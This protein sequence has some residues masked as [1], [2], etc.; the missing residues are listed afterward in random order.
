MEKPRKTWTDKLNSTIPHQIRR[1]PR[2]IAGMKKGEL[3]LVPSVR[4]VD[5]FIRSIPKGTSLSVKALRQALARKFRAEV[6]CPIYTGY[7]LRTVAEAAYEAYVGG[8]G[9]CDITPVWRVLDATAPTIGKLSA[10]NAVFIAKRRAREG[11]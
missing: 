10:E 5:D 3:A 4:I 8:A 1:M 2:D 9:L 7:H 11:L 6:T